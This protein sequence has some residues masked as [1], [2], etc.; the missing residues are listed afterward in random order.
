MKKRII[1][2][3]TETTGIV[4]PGMIQLGYIVCD[5]SLK[6]IKRENLFFD[7]DKDIDF[8]AM[9]VHHITQKILVAK[10]AED[11]RTDEEKKA[12]AIEDFKDAYLVAH[13]SPFDKWV[14]DCN[15]IVTEDSQWIDSYC[16]AYNKFTDDNMKHSLQYLRYFLDCE[17]TEVIDAHDALSDVIVLKEVFSRIFWDIREEAEE[18][19]YEPENDEFFDAMIEDTQRGIILRVWMFWKHKWKTFESVAKFDMQYMKWMY[20]DKKEKLATN[21]AL[22]NTLSFYINQ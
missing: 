7:T 8:W 13:N 11:S 10:L 18:A 21:D 6:E 16:I 3:D 12:L 2:L 20:N 17:F 15:E 14:L 1:F 9:A 19:G 22:F 4:D 5:L